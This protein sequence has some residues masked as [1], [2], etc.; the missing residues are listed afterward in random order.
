MPNQVYQKGTVTWQGTLMYGG[1][2]LY[3]VKIVTH[4]GDSVAF[5]YE[6]DLEWYKKTAQMTDGKNPVIRPAWTTDTINSG[7]VPATV[8]GQEASNLSKSKRIKREKNHIFSS[9][10][11][12]GTST[13]SGIKGMGFME[14]VPSNVK[15]TK[16]H[17]I[18]QPTNVFIALDDLKFKTEP[19]V[20]AHSILAER[21]ITQ[22]QQGY[23]SL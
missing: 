5:V 8:L 1:E 16:S 2:P 23:F 20:D 15:G 6:P 13:F 3:L 14:K 17:Y 12:Y 7:Y 11:E 10:I 4:N 22:P 19:T 9:R 18:G 21:G